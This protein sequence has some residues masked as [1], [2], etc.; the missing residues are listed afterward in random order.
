MKT[1][2]LFFLRAGAYECIVTTKDEIDTPYDRKITVD[3]EENREWLSGTMVGR[4][5]SGTI[6][7]GTMSDI[8]DGTGYFIDCREWMFNQSEEVYLLLGKKFADGKE[9]LTRDLSQTIDGSPCNVYL[10]PAVKKEKKS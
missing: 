3:L 5:G 1:I 4:F 7:E 6:S 8:T 10:F 2:N 9:Y